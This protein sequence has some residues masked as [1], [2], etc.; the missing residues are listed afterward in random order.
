MEQV[1]VKF[2]NWIQTGFDLYK[3]NI[4]ALILPSAL[5]IIIS[6]VT[7]GILAGPMMVGLILV[8]LRLL[9]KSEPK[10]AP[11]DVFQGFNYFIPA[12]LFA[13]VWGIVFFVLSMIP[14]LGLLLVLAGGTFLMFGLFLIADKKMEFWT[15]SMTS[16]EKVKTNFFPF[17]GLFVV[18]YIIGGIGII[19]CGIGVILTFPIYV[20]IISVAY[21]EAFAG[22]E[23]AVLEPMTE[24]QHDIGEDNPPPPPPQDEPRHD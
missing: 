17:L 12:F 20:C 5:A 9:D 16:F 15:A 8:T 14:F 3:Q 23:G 1:E 11:G 7:F 2:G 22:T 6:G 4:G 21:R 24:E 13:V 10:P 19:L 18:S